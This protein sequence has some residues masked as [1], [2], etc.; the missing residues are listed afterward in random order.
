MQSNSLVEDKNVTNFERNRVN[1]VCPISHFS[2]HKMTSPSVLRFF[3]SPSVLRFVYTMPDSFPQ[4]QEKASIRYG[5]YNVQKLSE[6]TSLL[7][8]N[9]S[10]SS[11]PK[12]TRIGVFQVGM[13]SYIWCKYKRSL[14]FSK[15]TPERNGLFSREFQ[16]FPKLNRMKLRFK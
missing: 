1:N 13:E 2:M 16:G 15:S 10:E 12:S 5:M 3:D 14:N 7:C 6:T 11:V 9:S 8:H 4:R